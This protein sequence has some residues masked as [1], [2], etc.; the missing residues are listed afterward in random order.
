M[1]SFRSVIKCGVSQKKKKFSQHVDIKFQVHSVPDITHQCV[2]KTFFCVKPQMT[3]NKIKEKI[4]RNTGV[5]PLLVQK[6]VDIVLVYLSVL[7]HLTTIIKENR[8]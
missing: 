4:I 3:I 8:G 1:N 2:E 7:V 6:D 5:L